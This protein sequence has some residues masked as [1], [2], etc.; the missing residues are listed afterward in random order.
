LSAQSIVTLLAPRT[1]QISVIA[2]VGSAGL[3]LPVKDAIRGVM[4]GGSV[5]VGVSRPLA[6]GRDGGW[7]AL[8]GV[9]VGVVVGQGMLVEVGG[10]GAVNVV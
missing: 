5:G 10:D 6:V 9:A 7:G 1:T 2:P 4:S 8:M 3:G